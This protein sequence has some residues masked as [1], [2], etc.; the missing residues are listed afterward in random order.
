MEERPAMVTS[1]DLKALEMLDQGIAMHIVYSFLKS[2]AKDIQ[3]TR[4]RRCNL[5]LDD[6]K[7]LR[8][9]GACLQRNKFGEFICLWNGDRLRTLNFRARLALKY[10]TRR[11]ALTNEGTPDEAK[12][13]AIMESF[14]NAFKRPVFQAIRADITKNPGQ[15]KLNFSSISNM[16][17]TN[18]HDLTNAKR[19]LYVISQ[20]LEDKKSILVHVMQTYHVPVPEDW[21]PTLKGVQQKVA[22]MLRTNERLRRYMVHAGVSA[23]FVLFLLALI[24]SVWT[25][26]PNDT[27]VW[28]I[29]LMDWSFGN[30]QRNQS[31]QTDKRNETQHR[32]QLTGSKV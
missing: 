11:S 22:Y 31:A 30:G 25:Q 6:L 20:V 16:P 8:N 9:L 21:S 10:K 12:Q 14:L 19:L 5:S 1:F 28:N 4:H 3:N 27:P 13:Q 29:G 18:T 15:W 26:D 2:S 24:L 7:A 17:K 32:S 23:G